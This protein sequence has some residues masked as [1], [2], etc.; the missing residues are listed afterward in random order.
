MARE[1]RRVHARL[2]LPADDF[3]ALWILVFGVY[4][5]GRCN[6]R[7]R[8]RAGRHLVLEAQGHACGLGCVGP[9]DGVQ[10]AGACVELVRV[11]RKR[12]RSGRAGVAEP[13]KVLAVPVVAARVVIIR[14][15]VP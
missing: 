11:L 1:R 2:L 6:P 13:R 9:H 14:V 8:E 7:V 10:Y 3:F 5:G 12:G 4:A 15:V